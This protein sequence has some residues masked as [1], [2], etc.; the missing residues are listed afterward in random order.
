MRPAR[1]RI[2]IRSST[3]RASA[4]SRYISRRSSVDRPRSA[5]RVPE[6]AA[7]FNPVV[8]LDPAVLGP[9]AFGAAAFGA[10]AGALAVFDLAARLDPVAADAERGVT[11]I[12]S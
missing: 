1:F 3:A 10:A 8:V 7:D 2:H 4:T 9:A 5:P 6:R 11:A 12:R